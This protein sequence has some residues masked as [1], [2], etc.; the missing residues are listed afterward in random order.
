MI[1]NIPNHYNVKIFSNN[2]IHCD[3]NIKCPIHV[4]Y[5]DESLWNL[6]MYEVIDNYKH[7][8]HNNITVL[9]NKKSYQSYSSA[10]STLK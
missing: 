6:E 2:G 1:N 8:I 10:K 7:P 5:Y 4:R 9:I 3:G